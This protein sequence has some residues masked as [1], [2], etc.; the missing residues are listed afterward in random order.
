MSDLLLEKRESV[1]VLTLNR[2]ERL[3]ALTPQMSRIDLPAMLEVVNRDDEIRALVITGAQ[4]GF[5]SGADMGGIEGAL[6]GQLDLPRNVAMQPLGY[7]IYLLTSLEKPTIAAINGVAAGGGF[8]LALACDFRVMS[9]N[10]KLVTAFLRIGLGPDAGMSYFLPRL[11]G[12]SRALEILLLRE[13]LDADEAEK[14]GLVNMIVPPD[15]LLA[16]SLEMAQRLADAP[17]IAVA[18]TKR[19]LFPSLFNDLRTQLSLESL[20][21]KVCSQTEDFKEGLSA[22]NEKRRPMF[23]GK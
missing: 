3:N 10:A 21:Q 23:K 4:R 14:L 16:T 12:F 22:R 15:A 17:P 2:P 7:Y 11:V 8:S 6:G 19:T 18:L 9:R 5:C 20:H 13:S 1:A